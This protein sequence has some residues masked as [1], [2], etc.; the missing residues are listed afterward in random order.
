MGND[1]PD[2][3]ALIVNRKLGI[4]YLDSNVSLAKAILWILLTMY[5]LIVSI[6]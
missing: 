2:E 5:K 4:D 3:C 6:M 1:Y